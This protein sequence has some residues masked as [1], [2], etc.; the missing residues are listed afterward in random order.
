MN[1]SA[2]IAIATI[3]RSLNNE[4]KPLT[5]PRYGVILLTL[6]YPMKL[7][8]Y[9]I[10]NR[11]EITGRSARLCGYLSACYS[12]GGFFFGRESGFLMKIKLAALFIAL[13]CSVA[14]ASDTKNPDK[15]LSIGFD[16]TLTHM[17]DHRPGVLTYNFNTQTI[18]ATF[19][20]TQFN[21]KTVIFDV[22]MPVSNSI[23][24][25]AH[26]GPYSQTAYSVKSNGYSIGGGMRFYFQD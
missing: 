24:V 21:Q 9:L 4:N 1:P 12:R 26:G 6:R 18:P 8:N 23:T 20:S 5:S 22:R 2:I 15:C 3:L 13:S 25:S 14:L 16:Y 11:P 10:R 7:L 17:T 19:D